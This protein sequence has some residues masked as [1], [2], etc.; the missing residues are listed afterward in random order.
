MAAGPTNN[1]PVSNKSKVAHLPGAKQGDKIKVRHILMTAEI[2]KEDSEAAFNL[3]IVSAL[4]IAEA[5]GASLN[6]V[7][8]FLAVV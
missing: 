1:A 3:A 8:A 5:A 2:T 6:A 4:L 7:F